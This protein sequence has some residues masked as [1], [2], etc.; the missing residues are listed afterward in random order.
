M[1]QFWT[2]LE[3]FSPLSVDVTFNIGDFYV[4]VTTKRNL[5]LRTKNGC[6][7]VMIG[8]VSINNDYMNP[9]TPWRRP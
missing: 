7:P 8:P 3:L 2:N 6:H 9:T 4:A 5:M 1:E